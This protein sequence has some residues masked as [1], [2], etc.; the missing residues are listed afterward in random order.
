MFR[1]KLKDYGYEDPIEMLRE[2]VKEGKIKLYPC[3]M[4]YEMMGF[5]KEELLDFVEEPVGA[6][7]F[8]E[9]SADAD[10]IIH[11]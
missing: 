8:F 2:G 5:K 1:K 11:M 10:N 6:A 9:I 4:T 7:T 3:S